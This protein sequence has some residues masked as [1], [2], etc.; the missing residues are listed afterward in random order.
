MQYRDAVVVVTGASSGIGRALAEAFAQRGSTVV[1]VAR[2][3]LARVGALPA[4]AWRRPGGSGAA[5]ATRPLPREEGRRL[6]C[7]PIRRG[8]PQVHVPFA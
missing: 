3:L 6:D 2:P 1:A 8:S 4:A 5:R 7:P